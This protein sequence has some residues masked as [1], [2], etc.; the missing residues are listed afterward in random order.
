MLICSDHV[1]GDR[2]RLFW[3]RGVYNLILQI[4]IRYGIVAVW[5]GGCCNMKSWVGATHAVTRL[6]SIP[7]LE[8][9]SCRSAHL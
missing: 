9:G 8:S 5:N 4:R 3:R 1:K 7:Y 6:F 2:T